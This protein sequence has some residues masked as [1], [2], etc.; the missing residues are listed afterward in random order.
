MANEWWKYALGALGGPVGLAA[1]GIGENADLTGAREKQSEL[2][3]FQAEQKKQR[4]ESKQRRLAALGGLQGPQVGEQSKARLAALQEESKAPIDTSYFDKGVFQGPLSQDPR[5]QAERAQA[6]TGG[7]S[8]LANVQNTQRATGASGGFRNIGSVSD[9]YDRLG[10]QMAQLSGRAYDLN[11]QTEAQKMQYVQG[12][13]ARREAK[14]AEA[15]ALE[16]SAIDAQLAFQNAQARARDA[17]EAGDDAA[18]M[19]ATLEAYQARQAG[20]DADRKLKMGIVGGAIQGGATAL[21]A[22]MGGPAGAAAGSKI[23]GGFAP[24]AEAV[25][26][27]VSPSEYF[28]VSSGADLM[29]DLNQT[30]M[31]QRYA[32]TTPW[33]LTRKMR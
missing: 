16:Q 17:I 8:A 29:A 4:E 24:S 2:E 28:G 14:R 20:I 26:P 31:P 33:S 22:Y 1:V 21:G 5:L 7:A 25:T 18:A 15:A 10:A 27:S 13:T 12:E 19:Q 6:V 9:I 23:G 11:R 3:R 30:P 32:S